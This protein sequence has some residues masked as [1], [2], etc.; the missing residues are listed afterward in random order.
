M[1]Y[2]ELYLDKKIIQDI[3][4]DG[5]GMYKK[6][7]CVLES[8]KVMNIDFLDAIDQDLVKVIPFITMR[9]LYSNLVL[10]SNFN[11]FHFPPNFVFYGDVESIST[12]ATYSDYLFLC[13]KNFISDIIPDKNEHRDFISSTAFHPV[14]IYHNNQINNLLVLIQICVSDTALK[15]FHLLDDSSSNIL[16]EDFAFYPISKLKDLK[17]SCSDIYN[18]V[19]LL[20]R[21]IV[22]DNLIEVRR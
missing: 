2:N 21:K 6:S 12:E 9:T 22:L 11:N 8:A 3:P 15:E 5:N 1:G 20:L 14:G 17:Y 4:F 10:V 13:G 7:L 16:G 19:N 18:N